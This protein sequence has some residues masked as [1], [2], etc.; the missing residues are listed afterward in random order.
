M[1]AVST[2]SMAAERVMNQTIHPKM[3]LLTAIPGELH[4]RQVL[5]PRISVVLIFIAVLC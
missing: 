2:K 1:Q 5:H 3:K 4:F